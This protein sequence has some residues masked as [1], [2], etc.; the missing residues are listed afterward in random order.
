[1][2]LFLF[3]K[4]AV[5]MLRQRCTIDEAG[6]AHF[7][8]DA[9]SAVTLPAAEWEALGARFHAA[10]VPSARRLRWSVPLAIP[11]VIAE[12][13]LMQAVPPLGALFDSLCVAL[14]GLTPMLLFSGLPLAAM[15]AHMLTVYREINRT[16]ALLADRPRQHLP[17]TGNSPVSNV[18]ELAAI[19]F[20]GPHILIQIYGT[21]VPDAFRNTPWTGTQ[22]DMSGLAGLAVFAALMTLRVRARFGRPHSSKEP[23][24]FVPPID[25]TSCA[26]SNP[27]RAQTFGRKRG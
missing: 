14:P 21:L 9:A 25:P 6:I 19:V 15:A 16:R 7:R 4:L 17:A 3:E 8:I 5:A 23:P 1:M 22:L 12:F 13:M 2:D 10:I 24:T 20:L 27:V 26:T 11:F 18:V